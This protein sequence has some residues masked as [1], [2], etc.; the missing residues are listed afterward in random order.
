MLYTVLLLLLLLSHL[1]TSDLVL[2]PGMMLHTML[3]FPKPCQLSSPLPSP[4]P[5]S[6]VH[7]GCFVLLECVECRNLRCCSPPAVHHAVCAQTPTFSSPFLFSPAP[8]VMLYTMLYAR[9]PFERPEDKKLNQHDRLQRILH[10]I[11]KAR[12]GGLLR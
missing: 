10:R 12:G 2:L 5:A 11:I 1:F 7:H 3:L 9:Y 4:A 8:G 6:A